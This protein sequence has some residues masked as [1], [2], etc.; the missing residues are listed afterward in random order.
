MMMIHDKGLQ[1]HILLRN[2]K[3]DMNCSISIDKHIRFCNQMSIRKTIGLI[4][5]FMKRNFF[6]LN[7]SC[8]F[9]FYSRWEHILQFPGWF[10]ILS[11]LLWISIYF[12]CLLLNSTI[13]D[14]GLLC[15]LVD[16]KN[17]QSLYWYNVF[18]GD[19]ALS[20]IDLFFGFR[21]ICTLLRLR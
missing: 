5:L 11:R 6:L 7:G 16:C 1:F 2:G 8:V 19:H 3:T 17:S 18:H 4:M 15:T 13:T 9:F 21:C 10:T 14:Y 20:L 12:L